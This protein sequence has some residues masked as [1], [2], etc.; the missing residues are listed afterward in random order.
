MRASRLFKRGRVA[1]AAIAAA[2]GVATVATTP[3]SATTLPTFMACSSEKNYSVEAYLPQ[4][5]AWTPP[6]KSWDDGDCKAILILPT[7]SYA[8]IYGIFDDGTVFPINGWNNKPANRF[9]F[10]AGQGFKISIQYPMSEPT[11][12]TAG[13]PNEP[14]E[15][16]QGITARQSPQPN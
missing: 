15:A 10:P 1:V 11:T 9:D 2:A 16:G 7:T 8:M 5:G 3:A 14:H 6:S 4:E 13:R 12:P